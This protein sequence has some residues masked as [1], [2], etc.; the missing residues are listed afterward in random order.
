MI[1]IS[2]KVSNRGTK[3]TLM[4]KLSLVTLVL[5]FWELMALGLYINE[6]WPFLCSVPCAIA[7]CFFI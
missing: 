6:L 2:K 4:N 1:E 3:R 5:L 7:I